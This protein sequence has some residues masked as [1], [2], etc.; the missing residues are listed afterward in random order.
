MFSYSSVMLLTSTFMGL[1]LLPVDV[2]G[3]GEMVRVVNP[4]IVTLLFVFMGVA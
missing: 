3:G 2:Y 4:S 1:G